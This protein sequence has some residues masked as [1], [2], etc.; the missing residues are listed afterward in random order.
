MSGA[1]TLPAGVKVSDSVCELG[2]N[3]KRDNAMMRDWA[4]LLE[5]LKQLATFDTRGAARGMHLVVRAANELFAN[6]LPL[7]LPTTELRL[8][9]I[10]DQLQCETEWR[11]QSDTACGS[12]THAAF[13]A[14]LLRRLPELEY[15]ERR[16]EP[17]PLP[18]DDTPLIN[19]CSDAPMLELRSRLLQL[20]R[21][22]YT[23]ELERTRP[24]LALYAS[25]ALLQWISAAQARKLVSNAPPTN[26][27]VPQIHHQPREFRFDVQQRTQ[28]YARW[29]D[30]AHDLIDKVITYICYF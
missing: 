7:L 24:T 28:F 18:L 5:P 19:S 30:A 13:V 2:D 9:T 12:D 11:A 14:M 10:A 1:K 22:A 8:R 25:D 20:L 27:L 26:V 23:P 6:A 16:V 3:W 15:L 17:A 4:P 21:D 29:L